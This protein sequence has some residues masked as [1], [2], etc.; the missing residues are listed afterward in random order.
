M[1]SNMPRTALIFGGLLVALGVVGFVIGGL[2]WSTKTA[3][4]PAVAGLPILILGYVGTLGDT[5]RKHAMH[6]ALLVALLGAL[7]TL[8]PILTRVIPGE[9]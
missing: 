6:V 5:A 3:L 9:A 2:D 7:A 8:P 4:I 1:V